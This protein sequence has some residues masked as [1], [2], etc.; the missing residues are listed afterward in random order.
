MRTGGKTFTARPGRG[1]G[2]VFVFAGKLRPDEALPE[3]GA[4]LRR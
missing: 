3:L 4:K 2:F 1:G